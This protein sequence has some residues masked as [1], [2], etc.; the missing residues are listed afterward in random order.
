M[1]SNVFK[2]TLECSGILNRVLVLVFIE[3]VIV[4]EILKLTELVIERTVTSIN[5]SMLP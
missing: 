4:V 3:L 1:T 5:S 2:T